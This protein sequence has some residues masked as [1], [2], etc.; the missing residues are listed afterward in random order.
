MYT[1]QTDI[2]T[3]IDLELNQPSNKIISIGFCV[4]NVQTGQILAS[5]DLFVVIDEPV[6]PYI[7]DLTTITD[8]ILLE[9]G[10]PLLVQYEKLKE[11]H[12]SFNA[13][14]NPIT[15]GGGDSLEIA[16]QLKST[17]QEFQWCFGRRW[18]DCKTVFVSHSISQGTP[19]KGGL[20]NSMKRHGLKF[21]GRKHTSK[22]DAINTFRFYCHL[23]KKY[24]K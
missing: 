21:E 15:W 9:K 13:F 18:I 23:L 10:Q 7:T 24:R 20:A 3:A 2:F 19:F 11:T 14:I 22:D 16:E 17:G 1:G 8:E 12:K 6:T 5:D 4:G